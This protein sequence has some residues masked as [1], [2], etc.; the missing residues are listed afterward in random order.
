MVDKGAVCRLDN[1]HAFE[2]DPA[3]LYDDERHHSVGA[4]QKSLGCLL[5]LEE[6]MSMRFGWLS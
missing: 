2:E 6:D 3:F 1:L 4:Y 5:I